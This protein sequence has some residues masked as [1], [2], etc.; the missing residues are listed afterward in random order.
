M[1]VGIL[2]DTQ[3]IAPRGGSVSH[4]ATISHG[5]AVPHGGEL[6]DRIAR[7]RERAE[8]LEKAAGLKKIELD[9][10]ELSDLE[11][12]A[13]GSFSPLRGFMTSADYRSVVQDMRLASGLVWSMPVVI[14]VGREEAET[15]KEGQELALVDPASPGKT[16]GGAAGRG[17]GGTAGRRGKILGTMTIEEKY[18]V[19]KGV[20]AEKV[21]RTMDPAH[22]GVMRLLERGEVLLGGEIRLLERP[23]RPGFAEFFLDPA[24]TRQE[25]A[26]RGWRRV[27]GFQTRNPIHR[28]HEYI[29]KCALEIVDGLLL[30]PLVGETKGDDVPAPVRMRS[31]QMMLEKYYPPERAML[32][33]FPAAMRYA[34]PREAIFHALVRKN[35]GCTHFIVGRDHAGVG[36]YYGSYDAQKIFEEFSTEE[37]GITPL[38]FEHTF[39]CRSCGN[40]ASAKTCPHAPEEHLALSGTRVRE[41]LRDGQIPPPEFTRP[42]VAQILIEVL[43]E[44]P[45]GGKRQ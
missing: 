12:I 30:H 13:N 5:G 10:W 20:E 39:Y 6:V 27:V 11:L 37:L 15:L 29:Q 22:P 3:K 14:G 26:R 45:A 19:K 43:A 17:A 23:A 44:S 34:G 35:Y 28:A 31:Y 2:P 8:L 25:F 32:S 41:M 36:N 42:E 40:M 24:Q 7:D 9:A 38:F 1:T 16:P 18:A 33:V 21:F 4:G